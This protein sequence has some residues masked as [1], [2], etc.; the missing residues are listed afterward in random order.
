MAIVNPDPAIERIILRILKRKEDNYRLIRTKDQLKRI[1]DVL[2]SS[3]QYALDTETADSEDGSCGGKIVAMSLFTPELGPTFIPVNFKEEVYDGILAK[4]KTLP[5]WKREMIERM[6]DPTQLSM[7]TINEALEPVFLDRQKTVIGHNF[8]FDWHIMTDAGAV[9][10]NIVRDTLV[11][12]WMIDENAFVGLKPRV[13][14]EFHVKMT[15]FKQLV[16]QGIRKERLDELTIPFV[17]AYAMAD[18]K[19]TWRLDEKYMPEIKRLGLINVFEKLLM[20]LLKILYKMERRGIRIDTD[21][22]DKIDRKVST[23]IAIAIR[24]IDKALGRTINLNSTK[25]LREV[26]FGKSYLNLKP[27][28]WTDGGKKGIPEPSTD[29]ETL[30]ELAKK[31][32]VCARIAELR[33]LSKIKGTYMDGL[34]AHLEDGRIH[35][36]FRMGSTVTGRLSSSDPNLQNIPARIELGKDIRNMFIADPGDVLIV[37]DLSNIELRMLAHYSQCPVMI[38]AFQN[39]EDLHYK[40]AQT[41]FHTVKPTKDQRNIAKSVNFGIVYGQGHKSLAEQLGIT[42]EESQQYINGVFHTYPGIGP[43]IEA[44]HMSAQNRG[45][46]RT[47]L[48]RYRRLPDINT[49]QT[50]PRGSEESKKQWAK[51]SYAQRQSVNSVIQGSAFDL[52]SLAMVKMDPLLPMFCKL[53]LQVHDELVFSCRKSVADKAMAIIKECMEN[54]IPEG[55]PIKMRVPIE[56]SITNTAVRWGEGKS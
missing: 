16:G 15:E 51:K 34:R 24:D 1:V 5:A 42:N 39:G 33:G 29:E 32:P 8:K 45:Y 28:K 26:L 23:D 41:I 25:Q 27:I 38:K 6:W 44:T 48:G 11:E 46:V 50:A 3:P 18:A 43:W 54:P 14:R 30:T 31:N 56:V 9:I 19:W 47:M 21:Q 10:R 35:T 40:T 17:S 20:P 36:N 22:L 12:A 4:A 7:A 52:L 53:L 2:K 13:L 55:S 37:G 49:P